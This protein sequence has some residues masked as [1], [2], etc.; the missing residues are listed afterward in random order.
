MIC[1]VYNSLTSSSFALISCPKMSLKSVSALLLNFCTILEKWLCFSDR[2]SNSY[3]Y[4]FVSD[5]VFIYLWIYIQVQNVF[6]KCP[7]FFVQRC[8]KIFTGLFL[9][10]FGA[11]GTKHTCKEVKIAF[12]IFAYSS[13][14]YKF[15]ITPLQT[16]SAFPG[17]VERWE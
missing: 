10:N 6:E 5:S 16:G 2:Q 12:A 3:I 7:P 9:L 4:V 17:S 13:T 14:K 15:N 8:R 1:S 11:V